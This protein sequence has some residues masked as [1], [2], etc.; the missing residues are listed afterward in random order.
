MLRP[1][2]HG[3]AARHR[4]HR[5]IA[6]L[7]AG[8][9][10]LLAGCTGAPGTAAP[11]TPD[12][13]E[14][15][16]GAAFAAEID[17][18]VT[19]SAVS[20]GDLWPSCWADDGELYA[21]NGDGSGFGS[22][23]FDIAVNRVTGSPDEEG[24]LDGEFLAGGDAVGQV[25][26]GEGFTRKPTG[27]LCVGGS[28]YLAVQDLRLDFNEAPA[29]TIA[30]SDD[31]GR[32]WVWDRSMPMFDEHE[33]TTV[34]FLDAGQGNEHAP[35]GYA[36]AYGLDGNWRDSFDDSVPDPTEL[37]LARVPVDAVQDVDR[38]E[39][40]AGRPGDA[41]ASW[42]ADIADKRPVLV[43]DRR[44]YPS[45]SGQGAAPGTADL[46]V[47][48]QGGVTNLPAQD[49]YVYTSWTELSFEFSEAPTPWGPWTLFLSEDFGPYPWT[50]ESFGG[51]GTTIPSKFVSDD[52]T[53]MWVQSNVC[54]C[55]PA[56]M[57]SYW[58]GLREL[59]LDRQ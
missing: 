33:F 31:G 13:G 17:R 23:V 18:H 44:R 49:R 36:Y 56:G 48:S 30:R 20:D 1:A 42:T 37:F 11:G 24:E 59:R 14:P 51:Y 22:E 54:P 21:A 29:A 41:E 8:G 32:T 25:W 4:I 28:I 38:W 26:S 55:A 27:M 19:A 12:L 46:S 50:D 3:G 57:S 35:D 7:A 58:F 52:G 6:S 39:F 40:Y 53:R 45:E 15:L 47:V 2:G 9:M 10:L 34:F 5:G 16:P 43:D